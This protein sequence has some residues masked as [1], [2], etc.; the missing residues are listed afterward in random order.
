MKEQLEDLITQLSED[1]QPR[2]WLVIHSYFQ[3][4]A[5]LF[6]ET[7]EPPVDLKQQWSMLFKIKKALD[8]W[9]S[10]YDRIPVLDNLNKNIIDT[11]HNIQ[12]TKNFIVEKKRQIAEINKILNDIFP[13]I[14]DAYTQYEFEKDPLK[15]IVVASRLHERQLLVNEHLERLNTELSVLN[16]EECSLTLI[17]NAQRCLEIKEQLKKMELTVFSY[18]TTVLNRTLEDYAYQKQA[19]L[20][21]LSD[22]NA[23]HANLS[24]SL[25]TEDI[26]NQVAEQEKQLNEINAQLEK[27]NEDI[28]NDSID[29]DKIA[30]T[31]QLYYDADDKDVF[32]AMMTSEHQWNQSRFNP[33]SWYRSTTNPD[34]T[35]KLD[36]H[37]ELLNFLSLI[38]QKVQAENRKKAILDKL[39]HAQQLLGTTRTTQAQPSD[40][41]QLRL[42]AIALLRKIAPDDDIQE[43][44]SNIDIMSEMINKMSLL[45]SQMERYQQGIQLLNEYQRREQASMALRTK[46]SI[47]KNNESSMNNKEL[48]SLQESQSARRLKIESLTRIIEKCREYLNNAVLLKD[49]EHTNSNL[50]KTLNKQKEN[51]SILRKKLKESTNESSEQIESRLDNTLL[52]LDR[53]LTEFLQN[54]PLGRDLNEVIEDTL[55]GDE[56][57][58]CQ[59]PGSFS[60]QLNIWDEAITPL[61]PPE[62]SAWFSKL[63]E[64]L[65]SHATEEKTCHQMA[66]LLRDIHF[67]LQYPHPL[68]N[69]KVLWDYH[70]L[71]P[72]PET[73][74][75]ALLA[76]KLP[77][78]L[79]LNL[80]PILGKKLSNQMA[81]LYQHQASLAEKYPREA[82]LLEQATQNLHQVANLIEQAIPGKMPENMQ[83]SLSDPRYENLQKHRG[84]LQ[85]LEW[86]AQVCTSILGLG[87]NNEENSY[88]NRFFFIPTHSSVLLEETGNKLA[89]FDRR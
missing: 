15:A 59:R 19:Y 65:K 62:L 86:L 63:F 46:Y 7:V 54:R 71:C 29:K 68:G 72:N 10:D 83:Q 74:Y 27:L 53:E 13:I 40:T 85:V 84:F 89:G 1:Q 17:A 70:R 32:M 81:A 47:L 67:E 57:E 38:H 21:S 45:S 66:Q 58:T 23:M 50:A 73:D 79:K 76:L 56:L 43:N 14:N 12:F 51:L 78:P 87:K 30:N 28:T 49:L 18:T 25:T 42:E 61:L 36:E 69:F 82:L 55:E 20:K 9:K 60:D 44:C 2:D 26:Q 39:E 11:K 52:N 24:V 88:R 80:K 64:T 77:L 33:F 41:R 8:G 35:L 37:G 31:V 6:N 3:E 4:N 34:Y 16:A 75:Q 22:V 5:S 48:L